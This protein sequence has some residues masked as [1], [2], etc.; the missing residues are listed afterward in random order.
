MIEIRAFTFF[1]HSTTFS[2]I[3][4]PGQDKLLKDASPRVI[5]LEMELVFFPLLSLSF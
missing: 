2:P 4:P 1:V 3:H 5:S